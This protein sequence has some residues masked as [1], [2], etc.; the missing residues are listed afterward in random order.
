MEQLDFLKDSFGP[1]KKPEGAEDQ[2]DVSTEPAKIK[3]RPRE[4]IFG[5]PVNPDDDCPHNDTYRNCP[6]CRFRF[7]FKEVKKIGKKRKV[8]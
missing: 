8:A 3:N 4:V 5:T 2:K 6:F 1:E 7:P